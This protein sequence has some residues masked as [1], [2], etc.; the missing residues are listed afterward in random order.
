MSQAMPIEQVVQTVYGAMVQRWDADAKVWRW[1][2]VRAVEGTASAP[3]VVLSGPVQFEVRTA[4][5]RADD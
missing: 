2:V 5:V 3:I 1:Y 4:P